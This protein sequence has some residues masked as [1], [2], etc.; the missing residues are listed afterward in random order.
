MT[1]LA[2]DGRY[3]VSGKTDDLLQTIA[4]HDAAIT[5]LSGRMTGV[6]QGL[7]T[8]QGEVHSGFA[9]IQ[10]TMT[11]QIG[12]LA[13][14]LDRVD[15][16]P[17]FDFHKIVGTVV[18]IAALFAMV[19]GGIIWINQSQTAALVAEQKSLNGQFG[20]QLEKHEYRLDQM[21]QWR[22]TVTPA[23]SQK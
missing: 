8:L 20:K 4:H 2:G 5:T 3:T 7:K 14:K 17:T 19:T 11:H 13:S 18:S 23:R 9:G 21:D 6:E 16:R 1:K 22:A 10:N 12:A 15:A